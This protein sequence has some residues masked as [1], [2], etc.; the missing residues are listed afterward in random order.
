MGTVTKLKQ[1]LRQRRRK[2]KNRNRLRYV[3][4]CTKCTPRVGTAFARPRTIRTVLSGNQSPRY[5]RIHDD[6]EIPRRTN[7]TI[8]EPSTV[9]QSDPAK[10]K[11]HTVQSFSK[12]GSERIRGKVALAL[13]VFI[14][15]RSSVLAYYTTV[16]RSGKKNILR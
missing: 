13:P 2:K 7:R 3:L 15:L 1:E 4:K 16:Q 8:Q 5:R 10:V 11:Y 12:N 9:Y 14:L 6:N